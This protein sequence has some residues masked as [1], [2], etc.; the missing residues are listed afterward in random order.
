MGGMLLGM[1][2]GIPRVVLGTAVHNGGRRGLE[3][4]SFHEERIL[5][6]T[7]DW[8]GYAAFGDGGKPELVELASETSEGASEICDAVGDSFDW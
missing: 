5:L 1:R 3:E 6:A 4:F 8:A 2:D 7:L